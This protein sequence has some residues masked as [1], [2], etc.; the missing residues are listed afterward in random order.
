MPQ[1]SFLAASFYVGLG[2]ALGSWL[3]FVVAWAWT[4]ALGPVRAGV[5]PYGTFTV[6]VL[7]CLAMGL[8]V[9]WLARF[10]PGGEPIRLLLG[11]GVLGGFTTF[12]SFGLDFAML[13]ERGQIGTAAFYTGLTLL[14]GFASLFAGLI[15]MRSV[16]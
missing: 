16:A 1:P 11:V 6:N 2:G 8:L 13:V 14:A 10:G 7:G 12:S 4:A 15:M 3:R 5:F 9:G